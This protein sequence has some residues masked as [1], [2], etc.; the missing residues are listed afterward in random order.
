MG[1][2][3]QHAA[4][5]IDNTVVPVERLDLGDGSVANRWLDVRNPYQHNTHNMLDVFVQYY[6]E[7]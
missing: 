5:I 1:R 7:G 4:I 2:R 3:C 6:R